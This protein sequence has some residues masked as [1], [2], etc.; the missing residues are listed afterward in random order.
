MPEWLQW[1]RE[2]QAISQTGL[3]YALG[4][5]DVQRYKRLGAIAAEIA[6]ARA[7][8]PAPALLEAFEAQAGYATP[9]ID[10]RGAVVREGKIL[11]V[12]EAS[13]GRW[14]MP[15]GW[16]DVGDTPSGAVAREVRE[17]SGFI[18][19]PR[20]VAGVFDANRDGTPREFFHAFKIIF[21]C[22]LEG[23]EARPSFETPNVAFFAF[24]G[25]PPL[26]SLR[27]NERHLA[28]VRK[29]IEDP[30]RPAAFD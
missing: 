8:V 28:E 4:E 11:L 2:L 24:D 13:D 5:Y 15:G 29:H 19:A 17:E 14:A 16:A 18:V 26:S 1:A 21:L 6:A 12:R 9:K 20:K 23:G 10:V 27:T 25:L 22:D 30:A 7:R 3:A